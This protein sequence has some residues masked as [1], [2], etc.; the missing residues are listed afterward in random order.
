M[1]SCWGVEKTI[2]RIGLCAS[3]RVQACGGG[4]VVGWWWWWWWGC[5]NVIKPFI[6]HGLQNVADIKELREDEMMSLII[7]LDVPMF[8]QCYSPN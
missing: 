7:V 8:L 3:V 4:V 5:H 2:P 6:Y 1:T